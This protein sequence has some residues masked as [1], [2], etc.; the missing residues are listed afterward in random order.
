MSRV[1]HDDRGLAAV[2]RVRSVRETDSRIGLQHVLAEQAALTSRLQRLDDAVTSAPVDLV[3]TPGELLARRTALGNVGVLA[4]EV[5]TELAT[6]DI[7]A[8]EA[9]ARWGAD[10]ARLAAVELL[11]ERRASVRRTE[12]ARREAREADDI[13]AQRWAQAREGAR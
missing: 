12:A 4:G 2:A 11:L 7:V 9:R 3:T 5:R 8:A 10:R 13:A 1:H 6:T